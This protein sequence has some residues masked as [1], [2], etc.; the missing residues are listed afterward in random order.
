LKLAERKKR[1]IEKRNFDAKSA[2]SFEIGDLNK[3]KGASVLITA[4]KFDPLV[5][6]LN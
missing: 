6:G 1:R 2:G 3:R 5:D 4:T